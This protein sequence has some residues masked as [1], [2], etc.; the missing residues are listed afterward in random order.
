MFPKPVVPPLRLSG[1]FQPLGGGTISYTQ[2][3]PKKRYPCQECIATIHVNNGVGEPARTARW[4]R[5][6]KKIKPGYKVPDV[7]DLV[8]CTEHKQLWEAQDGR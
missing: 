7:L 5:I 8:L 4:R 6:E 2:Y 1:Y 3:R